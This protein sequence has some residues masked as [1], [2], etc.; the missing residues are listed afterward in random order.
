MTLKEVFGGNLQLE[1]GEI[2]FVVR[3]CIEQVDKRGIIAACIF[4]LGKKFL[5]FQSV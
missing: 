4:F 1:D 5:T 2:P 3:A